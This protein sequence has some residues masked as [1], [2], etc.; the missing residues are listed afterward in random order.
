MEITTEKFV[1]NFHP[2]EGDELVIWKDDGR[3]IG[4]SVLRSYKKGLGFVPAITKLGK[5]ETKAL[6][7]IGVRIPEDL[8]VEIPLLLL[9]SKYSKYRSSHFGINFEDEDAPTQESLNESE[10]S[11]QP[12]DLESR[13]EYIMRLDP[14]S[15]FKKE[16]RKELSLDEIVDEIYNLHLQT[17]SSGRG[18][19]LKV[20]I[21][22]RN[23]ICI[24]IP[25]WI[26]CLKNFLGIFG[27]EIVND[28]NDFTIGLFKPYS[29]SKN[30]KTKYPH[31]L[32]FFNIDERVS[33][34]NIFGLLFHSSYFTFFI[35]LD[36]RLMKSLV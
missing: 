26:S 23:T 29:F 15:F 3:Y 4:F 32:P 6:I 10:N 35:L 7:K 36:E 27:K 8:I 1:A 11:K 31:S 18:K 19:I 20:K 28:N 21:N 17:I 25:K 33:L 12:I 22:L 14:T 13:D 24:I 5:E 16:T 9:V 2:K 34:F 30:I